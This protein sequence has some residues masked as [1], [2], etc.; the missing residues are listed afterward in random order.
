MRDPV[1]PAVLSLGTA[2][3]WWLDLGFLVHQGDRLVLESDHLTVGWAIGSA[4]W[5][6][7]WVTLISAG[8][9]FKRI[10]RFQSSANTRASGRWVLFGQVAAWLGVALGLVSVFILAVGSQGL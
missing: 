2:V 8:V 5:V 10:K 9:A 7:P 1:P 6:L 4:I 3:V